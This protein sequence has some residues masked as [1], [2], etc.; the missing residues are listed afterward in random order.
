MKGI[1]ISNA[2]SWGN[3]QTHVTKKLSQMLEL[4][5]GFNKE[6][7]VLETCEICAGCKSAGLVLIAI[8]S[9]RRSGWHYLDFGPVVVD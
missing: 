6:K 5:R 2:K 4:T 9:V 7:F 1:F 3:G 8:L